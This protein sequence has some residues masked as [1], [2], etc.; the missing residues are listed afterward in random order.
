MTTT[1]PTA[2]SSPDTAPGEIVT[3]LELE[4]TTLDELAQVLPGSRKSY[5]FHRPTM[6]TLK[7]LGQ[8]QA[9]AELKRRPGMFVA[10]YLS[11]VLAELGGE[12]FGP[13]A[14]DAGRAVKVGQLPT[15]D[16]LT[17]LVAWTRAQHPRGVELGG[18]GCGVCGASWAS[19]KVDL[20]ELEVLA[21]PAAYEGRPCARVG[22]YDG[23]PLPGGKLARVVLLEAPNWA[24]SIGQVSREGWENPAAMRAAT[25][26][27]AIRSTDAMPKVGRLGAEALD[28]LMPDDLGLIDQ[29][30][31]R[32]TASVNLALTVPCP[33]CS[34]ENMTSIP[35]Q[36]LGFSGGPARL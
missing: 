5:R 1:D 22:L 24:E 14:R 9:D 35:W 27:G 26:Q 31:G 29:A 15:G 25:V 6:G 8:L 18:A 19:V 34:A 12:D 2:P 3:D 17:L 16:V 33:A 21:V 4:T 30:L 36:N 32:I 13:V 10:H 20:G 28:E 11:M 7:L 23:F